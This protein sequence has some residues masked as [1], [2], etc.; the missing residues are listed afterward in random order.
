MSLAIQL[1]DGRV[2]EE[3]EV[4]W[5]GTFRNS[6]DISIQSGWSVFLDVHL[7][8]ST[9]N[10]VLLIG[11]DE[12][13]MSEELEPGS[14]ST[15]ITMR[16]TSVA[17]ELASAPGTDIQAVISMEGRASEGDT[18]SQIYLDLTSSI[19]GEAVDVADPAIPVP[20]TFDVGLRQAE[21]T[22]GNQFLPRVEVSN[23]STVPILVTHIQ[24]VVTYLDGG[25]AFEINVPVDTYIA[26]GLVLTSGTRH[27]DAVIVDVPSGE[28]RVAVDIEV[29]GERQ[30]VLLGPFMVNASPITP[31]APGVLELGVWVR[32]EGRGPGYALNDT[33]I[34][35]QDY[36]NDY[37]RVAFLHRDR[38]IDAHS[39]LMDV[40]PNFVPRTGFGFKGDMNNDGS[41]NALDITALELF[42]L[43]GTIVGGLTEEVATWRGDLNNDGVTDAADVALIERLITLSL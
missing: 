10:S 14:E 31:T 11:S 8:D 42:V 36:G 35:T 4:K 2:D 40:H 1:P 32:M 15:S 6:G 30:R 21:V 5:S 38:A 19:L 28:Y 41:L 34:I 3:F 29:G 23:T 17:S 33:G 24:V 16:V 9:G 27:Q 26:P 22:N 13:S 12:R 37:F 20:I 39:S 7:L 43:T 18:S 25:T